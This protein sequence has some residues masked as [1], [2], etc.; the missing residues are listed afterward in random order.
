MRE[1]I[2][3]FFSFLL[4]R[5]K[6]AHPQD[7]L[8]QLID[9]NLSLD[10]SQFLLHFV[11]TALLSKDW[12]GV[13][14]RFKV[15]SL[16]HCKEPAAAE[17]EYITVEVEDMKHEGSGSS[18]YLMLLERTV[19]DTSP[20]IQAFAEHPNSPDVLKSIRN[21]LAGMPRDILQSDSFI[22]DTHGSSVLQ[23]LL[24]RLTTEPPPESSDSIPLLPL[25]PIEAA[26]LEPDITPAPSGPSRLQLIDMAS[27]TSLALVN[28][29]THLISA[30]HV[31]QDKF[32]GGKHLELYANQFQ[33]VR[34]IVPES[35]SLF[36]LVVLADVVHDHDP[37]YSLLRGQCYWFVKTICD[38][39]VEEYACTCV[40]GNAN[41]SPAA[42]RDEVC[43]SQK[44]YLPDTS[45]RWMGV[46][47][48]GVENTVTLIVAQNFR[49]YCQEKVEYIKKNWGE[50]WGGTLAMIAKGHH[51]G[52][53]NQ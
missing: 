22:N 46:M 47:I 41:S 26:E 2:S 19:S 3:R 38:V 33:N 27:V 31:A 8:L 37:L 16:T 15:V 51:Q 49:A 17:H 43:T 28:A 21:I 44:N 39:V 20:S 53:W 36:E 1:I 45:G 10:T 6:M 40:G 9:S 11:N 24:R 34:Q 35:L 42:S 5:P 7:G 25:E 23:G 32:T 29:S 48:T 13:V 12:E 50:H 18:K 14:S 4:S 30:R 52:G